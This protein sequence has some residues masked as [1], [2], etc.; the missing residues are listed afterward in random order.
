MQ[1]RLDSPYR[2]LPTVD[3]FLDTWVEDGEVRVKEK[4]MSP[5]RRNE[6]LHGGREKRTKYDTP[7]ILTVKDLKVWFATQRT[8]F[9]RPKA[10][11]KAVDG[12]DFEVYP[13]QTLGL[14]GESGCGK[15]T[16]GRAIL[17]LVHPKQGA[18]VFD[19]TDLGLLDGEGQTLKRTLFAS[20]AA[21]ISGA[22]TPAIL[23]CAGHQFGC[24]R[25]TAYIRRHWRS[26]F[27]HGVFL[28]LLRLDASVR[29]NRNYAARCK[30]SS[31]I[32]MHR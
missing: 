3:D 27:C 10:W 31:R 23:A 1:T 13:G 5:E 8:I 17:R 19:G 24:I 25:S 26:V 28:S 29:R 11:V 22:L 9:G 6:L 4:E 15:T 16:T 21:L 20:S 12:I 32:R 7:P 14:V 30:S 2:L 18:T